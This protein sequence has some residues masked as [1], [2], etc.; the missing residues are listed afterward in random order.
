MSVCALLGIAKYIATYPCL[1]LGICLGI[2][3]S[4][5]VSKVAVVMPRS[6]QIICV[7]S[8]IFP[9]AKC[10]D[11]DLTYETFQVDGSIASADYSKLLAGSRGFRLAV[12]IFL[13]A[14]FQVLHAGFV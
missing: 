11:L 4:I 6:M 5:Q 14:A 13:A 8:M 2:V 10:F 1:V 7:L 3:V 9:T 12:L